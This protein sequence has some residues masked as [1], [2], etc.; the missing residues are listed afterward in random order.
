MIN[1]ILTI[2]IISCLFILKVLGH[3]DLE[4]RLVVYF[5]TRPVRISLIIL[6][7][8]FILVAI[9]AVLNNNTIRLITALILLHVLVFLSNELLFVIIISDIII[10]WI[11]LGF[12]LSHTSQYETL[13]NSYLLYYILIPSAPLLT[14]AFYDWYIRTSSSTYKSYSLFENE[15]VTRSYFK[16]ILLLSRLAKL[17]VFRF[18]YWLPKAHVQSPTILSIILAGLSLKVRLI[19]ISY[20]VLNFDL[21]YYESNNIYYFLMTRLLITS[22]IGSNATD[23][24]VFLAYCSVSHISLS[25]VRLSIILT[26]RFKRAWLIRLRHCLSSPILFFLAG[27]SQYTIHS[28]TLYS[29][30][31]QKL[32]IRILILLVLLLLDLPFPP[33]FSFWRELTLLNSIYSNYYI[34]SFIILIPLII[35]LRRY[36][37]IYSN[38]KYYICSSLSRIT[39]ITL[40]VL[41]F[42]SIIV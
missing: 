24:K 21:Y 42:R 32:W 26:L 16:W 19:V 29:N 40:S 12:G 6:S 33:S 36:E 4:L 35:I 31:R 41:V 13:S 8:C 38:I 1:R 9:K 25:A 20:L 30:K 18:H 22:Y 17:P 23:T 28:R 15:I 39:F 37:Y 27:N 34:S 2:T 14:L 10:V 3:I 5:I 7:L 11:I